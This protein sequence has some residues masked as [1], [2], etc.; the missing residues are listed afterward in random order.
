MTTMTLADL[1][2]HIPVCEHENL[3]RPEIDRLLSMLNDDEVPG[4]IIKAGLARKTGLG[5]LAA[6]NQHIIFLAEN[7]RNGKMHSEV[8]NYDYVMAVEWTT[9]SRGDT[10]VIATTSR[11][12]QLTG[13]DKGQAMPFAKW[14]N[15]AR[16]L[17]PPHREARTPIAATP[18]SDNE[19][20]LEDLLREN[21]E[22]LRQ[23]I[24]VMSEKNG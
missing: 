24:A 9:S 6:T 10:V 2:Q 16:K 1:K 23:L 15:T 4:H 18:K 3:D 19:T 8:V 11:R 13:V 7:P 20:T 12:I 22:L 21:N 14:S 5:I 17:L